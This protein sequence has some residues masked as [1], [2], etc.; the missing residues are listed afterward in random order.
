MRVARVV[1][2]NFRTFASLDVNVADDLCCIIGENNTGKTAI[3]SAIQICL[4]NT[5]PSSFRSLLRE[6]IH[7]AVDISNPSQVLIGIELTGF[8]GRVNEEALVSTWK[9]AADRARI[10]YRFRPRP[11]V[12]EQLIRGDIAPGRLV[13][14][15]YHWEIRGGGDPAIDLTEIAW[16]DEGIGESVRFADLQAYLIVHLPALRDVENDLRN[17]RQSPLIRLIEAFEIDAAEQAALIAIL[18]EANKAIANSATVA[19]IGAAIDGR[20]KDVSGPAFEMD[21]TLGLSA[22]TFRAI[23]RNLKIILSDLSLASFEPGR[24]GLGMNNI[25]YI[26]ILMEYLKRR[27]ALDRSAGQLILIEEPEAHLHPQLQFSLIA[28]LRAIGVQTI[29]TSHSTQVTSQVPLSSIVSLTKRQDATI[30]AGNLALN[31]TLTAPEIADLER[32][33]DATKS[34]L[35]YARK[36]ILVE[37]PAEMFLVPALIE[38]VYGVKL[39]RLGVSVIAIHGIHFDVYAKLFRAGSLEKKCAIVADAD[40]KPS[41]AQDFDPETDTPNLMALEGDFVSVF[42]GATTFEREL[43]SVGRLPMLIETVRAL[44]VPRIL[45]QMEDGHAKL[46]LGGL[47]LAEETQLRVELGRITLNTAKRFGKARFAQ[48]AARYAHLATDLPLYIE[49]AYEWLTE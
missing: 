19:E 7:S 42:I 32:Y 20:F 30:A 3:L 34:A 33:L 14:E 4:D 37:G 24:N 5:L 43:V 9:T 40:M 29:L 6:D 22:A 16:D 27:I 11:S 48:I 39:E 35:L 8:E 13:L 46:T 31:A 47:G 10:F 38:Q 44:G 49:Q 12:R 23:I 28:A 45:A 26:A 21:A 17:P 1:I 18:D 2:R 25:L 36:V 15:D 41:D